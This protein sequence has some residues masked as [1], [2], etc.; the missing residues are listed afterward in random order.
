VSA[1]ERFEQTLAAYHDGELGWLQRWRLERRLRRD[2]EARRELGSL[3]AL[4]DWL[5]EADSGGPP[6]PE[7]WD[8]IQRRLPDSRPA[9]GT[10]S[11]LPAEAEPRVWLRP[12]WSWA[13]GGA[14][15]AAAAATALLFVS[16]SDLGGRGAA[17]L[18]GAGAVRWLDSRGQPMMILQDDREATLIW[19]TDDEDRVSGRGKPHG[20]S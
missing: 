16:S 7:L 5:R 9:V 2:P 15:L 18:A 4:G 6:A 3:S 11:R 10:E 14:A 19:V 8:E 12:T 1:Q 13:A 17:P 20:I